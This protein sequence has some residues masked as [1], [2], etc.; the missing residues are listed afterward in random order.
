MEVVLIL[1]GLGLLIFGGD[2]L[3]KGASGLALKF[4]MPP[5]LIGMTVVAIGTSAPELVVSLQAAVIGKP[6]I[7]IGN[8]VGSNIA[9][10]GLILGITALIFPVVIRRDVI[11]YDWTAMMVASLLFYFAGVNGMIQ[12]WEGIAFV[13]LLAG[14]IAYSF[15]RVRKKPGA[16]TII[17]KEVKEVKQRNLA[18]LIAFVVVGSAGLVFG[19]RW[20]LEGAEMVA[21]NF[22]VSDRVIAITLVAFGT[23]VPELAASIIA[24]LKKEDE[25]FIGNILGSNLFNLLA[26]IGI[27]AGIHPISFSSDILSFDIF[28]MLGLSFLILPMGLLGKKLSRI[29]GIILLGVYCLYIYLVLSSGGV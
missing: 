22:G 2:Y 28:W 23:S 9:N 7:S 11:R 18:V 27:T 10:V 14:F 15:Y 19:A 8:V 29:D 5:V 4:S 17:P 6:D 25:L 1:A 3:V 24:A 20:F 21:R 12:R 26:I 16:E 13:I